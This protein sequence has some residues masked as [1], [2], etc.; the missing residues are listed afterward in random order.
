VNAF[1]WVAGAALFGG[2]IFVTGLLIGK[3]MRL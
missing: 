1:Y 3:A 2:L